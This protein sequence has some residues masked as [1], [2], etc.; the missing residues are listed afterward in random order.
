MIIRPAKIREA[1]HDPTLLDLVN[2]YA[3]LTK[4]GASNAAKAIAYGNVLDYLEKHMVRIVRNNML[5]MLEE[6]ENYED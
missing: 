6:E 5:A 2:E 4:M 1:I 3:G